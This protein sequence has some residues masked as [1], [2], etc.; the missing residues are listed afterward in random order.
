MT[1]KIYEDPEV[2]VA[3]LAAAPAGSTNHRLSTLPVTI[4][5]PL[6]DLVIEMPDLYPGSNR[7]IV[8]VPFKRTGHGP[9]PEQMPYPRH[10]GYWSCIVVASNDPS[11]KVGGYRL[12]ISEH[13]LVRGTLRTPDIGTAP[14]VAV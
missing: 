4:E 7:R 1:F 13:E 8:V 5:G 6:D 14:I 9:R 10:D 2:E 11:Y 3:T 12:D